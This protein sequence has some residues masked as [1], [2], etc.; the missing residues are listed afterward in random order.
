MLGLK[1]KLRRPL[2][3]YEGRLCACAPG[4]HAALVEEVVTKVPRDAQVLDIGAHA[5]A[6]LMRLRNAGFA[7]LTGTDLDPTRFNV[8]GAQ[9]RRLELNRQFSDEFS[10]RF[11]LITCTDVIEHLDSPRNFV[12]EC[13]NLLEDGGWLAISMPNVA[14]WEGRLKFLLTGELWGFGAKN[15]RSQRHISPMTSEQTTLMLEECG[16]EVVT[17]RTVG[18]F[19]TP[20]RSILLAPLRLVVR[21]LGGERTAG[22]CLLIVAKKS[23]PNSD[24]SAPTHYRDRWAGKADNIGLDEAGLAS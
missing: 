21:L 5:G 10:Q 4:T 7:N 17:V 6:L 13:R 1:K 3:N 22:E 12:A 2:E 14:F 19:A 11:G 16:Y 20:L 23:D 18:S 24:L 9:F 15:Y 8:P